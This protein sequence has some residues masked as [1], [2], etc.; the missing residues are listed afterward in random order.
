MLRYLPSTE[1]TNAD[2]LRHI[3]Q[4]KGGLVPHGMVI[5]AESQR[6]GRGR[7]GRSWYSPAEGNIY[8]SLVLA[9]GTGSGSAPHALSWTPLATALA[10]AD[11]LTRQTGLPVVVKWPNDVMIKDKK[12]GGILCEQTMTA[13]K[14]TAIVVGIG[15][16]INGD[17]RSMPSDL[18]ETAT[19]VAAELNRPADRTAIL[20]DLFVDLERRLDLLWQ[21]GPGSL[22]PEYSRRC[23]TLGKQVRITF[24]QHEAVE[25]LAASIGED[26]HLRINVRSEGCDDDAERV[27]EVRSADVVHLRE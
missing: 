9:A 19:S 25:G 1:S 5:V 21:D 2:A 3:Q 23:E 18:Q 12:L 7:R 22:A 10:A 14:Q 11:T 4:L 16:N 26:G 20:A 17:L 24:N 13:D 8:C 6:A 15:L 27:I